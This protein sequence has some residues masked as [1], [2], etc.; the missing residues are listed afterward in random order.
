MAQWKSPSDLWRRLRIDARRMRLQPT[1]AEL[2]FWE[3]VRAKRFYGLKFR[4]QHVIGSFIVDFYCRE[5]QVVIEL[6]G[7]IHAASRSRDLAREKDLKASGL[8]VMR[9]TNG[10]V[11]ND[12]PGVLA[13]ISGEFGI[14]RR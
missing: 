12:L 14:D 1:E 2:T 10:D 8:R 4:R 5:L 7:G 13:R 6:E 11:L 3:A 9:F